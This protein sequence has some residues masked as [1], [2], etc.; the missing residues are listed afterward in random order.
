MSVKSRENVERENEWMKLIEAA[1]YVSGR[2]LDLKKLGSV[3]GLRSKKTLTKLLKRLRENYTRRE[4]ALEIVELENERYVMQL[5][6]EYTNKVR[7]LTLRPLLTP[8]PLKTLSY[9]AFK[10]PVLQSQVVAVRGKHAYS[11]L[12]ELERMGLIQ[13]K[14]KGRE[15]IVVTTEFF[16]DYFSLS[17]KLPKLK[18]QLRKIFL[19]VDK[20]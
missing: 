19:N 2:P 1:L 9:I 10:Q 14:K 6:P 12:R 8:G 17:R 4:T 18:E 7:K 3:S 20:R 11:H 13:R 15:R 5:K 16:S